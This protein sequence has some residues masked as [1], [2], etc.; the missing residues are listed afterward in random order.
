MSRLAAVGV[1]NAENGNIELAPLPPLE[2]K[3]AL[4]LSV[5]PSETLRRCS[6][7]PSV[8]E[9]EVFVADLSNLKMDFFCT[10]RNKN[11]MY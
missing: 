7:L 11:V 10:K 3:A 1:L 4:R 2:F 8:V 9:V 5:E 6:L